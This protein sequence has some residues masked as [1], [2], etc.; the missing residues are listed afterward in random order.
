MNRDTP[1]RP[2]LIADS[3]GRGIQNIL[4]NKGIP[5]T[6]CTNPGRG[7]VQ[8]VL[9]SMSK[10]R[11]M[12]PSLIILCG[13]ICDITD[14]Y[15]DAP[16]IRMRFDNIEDSVKYYK[17]QVYEAMDLLHESF[18]TIPIQ[19]TP[20]IGIDIRVYNNHMSGIQHDTSQTVPYEQRTFDVHQSRLNRTIE[21]IN[22]VVVGINK[23]NGVPIPWTANVIHAHKGKR[24]LHRYNKL[25]DGCH[26]EDNTK[27]EWCNM[28]ILSFGKFEDTNNTRPTEYRVPPREATAG[29]R[30]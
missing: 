18:S 29:K 6:V 23:E 3:R 4:R 8:S 28:L 25:V 20:T 7:I 26:L 30:K 13:S 10:I 1:R 16:L 11:Q 27:Y 19:I 9:A 2:I 17:N 15:H 21:E 14:K 22:Y 24:T 5:A 12:N